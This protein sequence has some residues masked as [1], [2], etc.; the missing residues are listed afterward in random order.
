M[1]I[2]KKF[3]KNFSIYDNNILQD[4]SLSL[5][6]RGLYCFMA[7]LPD[8][9]DFSYERLAKANNCGYD[10]IKRIM[11]ELMESGLI[12]REFYNN[13][14]GNRKSNY[15]IYDYSSIPSNENPL[16][17]N[18]TKENPSKE[19]VGDNIKKENIQS[20]KIKKEKNIKKEKKS[21]KEILRDGTI[22]LFNSLENEI[23]HFSLQDWL[24][25]VDYKLNKESKITM[26]TF[27]KN[28]KQLISF[29]HNAKLSIE[30][31]IS[32]GW[33]GLFEI[34]TQ[35]N[36]SNSKSINY[37]NMFESTESTYEFWNE[38]IENGEYPSSEARENIKKMNNFNKNT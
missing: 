36:S 12:A 5:E 37:D 32:A 18:P 4:C 33:S 30:R 11:D 23:K 3:Q 1:K 20:N 6:A 29:G 13:E 28:I 38:L 2:F 8:D 22:N 35:C 31:S 34:K 7:S 24:E 17:E 25:W 16:V 21:S 14:K 26:A 27:S 15:F 9:W 19:K 10:R